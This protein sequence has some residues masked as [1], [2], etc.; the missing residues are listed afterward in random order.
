MSLAYQLAC[1]HKCKVIL[2][3]EP[4]PNNNNE[5][6]EL[7][8][9]KSSNVSTFEC[10]ILASSQLDQLSKTIDKHYSGIDL[11]IDNGLVAQLAHQNVC[12]FVTTTSN[13]LRATINVRLICFEWIQPFINLF[14]F[15]VADVFRT[16]NEVFFEWP[17]GQHSVDIKRYAN[18]FA[19]YTWRDPASGSTFDDS[20][21][22][23]MPQWDWSF[24]WNVQT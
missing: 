9:Q 17:C 8:Y 21:L 5:A 1:I 19:Q 14:F 16:K 6:R 23:P 22:K 24:G 11:I 15:T 3:K 2:V 4:S 10:D 13:K 12:D 18:T 20:W 7:G